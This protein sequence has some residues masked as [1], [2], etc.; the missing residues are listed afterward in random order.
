MQSL[1]WKALLTWYLITC[2]FL[3][4]L[5]VMDYRILKLTENWL[6]RPLWPALSSLNTLL[7]KVLETDQKGA[8]STVLSLS[9]GLKSYTTLQNAAVLHLSS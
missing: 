6:Q 4:F 7:K 9:Q 1:A 5:P 2:L 8:W 3:N